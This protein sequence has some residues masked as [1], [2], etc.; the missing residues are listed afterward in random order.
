MREQ[1][2]F[3]SAAGGES[4]QGEGSAKA[5]SVGKALKIA[6]LGCRLKASLDANGIDGRLSHA[7]CSPSGRKP[8]RRGRTRGSWCLVSLSNRI[9][10]EIPLAPR[11][12]REREAAGRANHFGRREEDIGGLGSGPS[13]FVTGGSTTG[14]FDYSASGLWGLG[15]QKFPALPPWQEGK[16]GGRGRFRRRA[17]TFCTALHATDRAGAEAGRTVLWSSSRRFVAKQEPPQL[18]VQSV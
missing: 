8:W 2:R 18:N 5:S 3:W 12:K 9:T 10:F 13:S 6:T 7:N 14:K 16:T 17:L 4:P 11:P 1:E 15:R